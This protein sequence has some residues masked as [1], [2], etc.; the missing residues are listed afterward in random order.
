MAI[1]TIQK[2]KKLRWGEID[3]EEGDYDF[4]LPP[5]QMISPDQNGV[6]KVIEYKFNEE[7]KK[8][9]IT[10]TTRV[11]K[12]ALTKQAVERRSWNKF[13]DAAHEESS[14]YLTMR[15]TEDIILER[16]RAP[17]KIFNFAF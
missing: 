9:K 17:G 8:V 13:G 5:K 16:I 10:T 7:D 15:S 2:T 12:R 6:K 4:L 1:D 11:Q 14:S 3:E